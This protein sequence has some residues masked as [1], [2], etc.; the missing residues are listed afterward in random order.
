MKLLE[1][2]SGAS[3]AVLSRRAQLALSRPCCGHA[4]ALEMLLTAGAEGAPG[5]AS[6]LWRRMDEAARH[7]V[8][9]NLEL[10]GSSLSGDSRREAVVALRKMTFDARVR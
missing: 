2:L 5:T 9:E 3:G 1:L 8:A 7:R 10:C 4:S 6:E